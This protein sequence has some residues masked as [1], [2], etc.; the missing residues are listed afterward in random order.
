LGSAISWRTFSLVSRAASATL[1]LGAPTRRIVGE[2]S[3][4]A[5]CIGS[6][7]GALAGHVGANLGVLTHRLIGG[8]AALLDG[9]GAAANGRIG[10]CA[11]VLWLVNVNHVG[12]LKIYL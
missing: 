8:L 6:C 1:R 10:G 7:F 9:F 11:R 3:A 2:V 12:L 5:G 4:A